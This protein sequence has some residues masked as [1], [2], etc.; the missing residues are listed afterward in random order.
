[1]RYGHFD[2]E[3]REYVIERPDTPRSWIN[4]SG[5]RGYGSIITNNAGGYSF[6]H[7]SAIARFLR[8]RFNSVPM[9]QPGRYFYLRDRDN[10]DYWSASW[11]PVG[12]PLDTY[13]STCRFGTSYTIIDS[14]YSGV[15]TEST[16][17]VP[18][19]Q[20]F[21][22]WR[23][24]VTNESDSPRRLSVFTFCEFASEWNI[25]QDHFNIQYSSY[26]VR[27][28]WTGEMVRCAIL[29]NVPEKPS[30]FTYRHQGR[31]S[32]MALV[33]AEVA[34]YEL[35]R[36]AFL[37]PYRSFHNPLTV[38][39]GTCEGSEA[40]GDNA[41]GCLQ[42]NLELAPGETR[43]VLVLLGVGKPEQE[44]RAVMAEYGNLE[45]AEQELQR[46][47]SHWHGLLGKLEVRTPD[48]EFDHMV[49]M[50]NAYNSLI[51]FYWSRAASLVYTG[52]QRDG[53]GYRDTVQDCLGVLPSVAD[54]VRER[55][56]LM[57]TGQN[58][59]GG[60]MPEVKPYAHSPGRMSPTPEE[61]YRSD[62]ALWLFNAVPAY[63]AETGDT[64]FYDKVL[65]YC[66]KGEDTVLG[67][68]RRALL[69][70]LERTGANGLPCGLVADWNDCLRLGFRGES[71]FVA[72]QLR[73][74]LR[75]YAEI[76]TM[77]GREQERAWAEGELKRY[78]EVLRARTWDGDWFIRAFREDG[79]TLGS[80][81]NEEGRIFLNPQSWA[82]ISGAATPE[83]ASAAMNAVE[84]DLA[85][86]YGIMTCTPPFVNADVDVVLALLLNPGQKEN[87]GIFSHPQSWAVMADCMLGNGDRAYRHYRAFMPS[88]SNDQAELRL[89]EPFVHCQ[90]TDSPHSPHFG[91]S[92]IPWLS[93]TASWACYTAAQYI[94]GVRP[95]ADGITLDPCVPSSWKHFTLKRIFRG[96]LLDITVENPDGVQKG[97]ASLVLNG[98][99]IQGNHIPSG[100]L[101]DTNS[102]VVTMG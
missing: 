39:R 66:D 92:H 24:R 16:Y 29:N 71:A 20:A 6:Y 85:T 23:L 75:T 11:Q 55:L 27:S 32:W 35:D 21:E 19:D 48:P 25:F 3:K 59:T 99:N 34:G 63:V 22:Y 57:I 69:F 2:D 9:D 72:F 44:G 87:A 60:A 50:W 41:C 98:T 74:G 47:R 68:L 12:K 51:T 65:P 46:L 33:G 54:E 14:R 97:V 26:T 82:V 30:D 18:L 77:L 8:L 88:R 56:E 15:R 91:R 42:A 52:D 70:N 67:H 62:D 37:G 40:Y 31:W 49:N 81:A 80:A 58:S 89:I 84:N 17:F 53:F 96:K 1:M 64:A 90:S 78:D 102:I 101:K 45:R 95:E 4:Y 13:E 5:S 86:E 93:G 83:Q 94:L 10:G 36:E 7:S 28:Q 43:E 38:E 61:K 100:E 76:C 73:F 79:E